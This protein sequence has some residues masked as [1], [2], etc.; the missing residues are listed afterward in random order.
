MRK[1][2]F[3]IVLLGCFLGGDFNWNTIHAQ[4]DSTDIERLQDYN[5]RIMQ[6]KLN[7]IYIPSNIMDA[8][9]ELKEISNEEALNKFKSASE[10]GIGRRLFFGLGKWITT[11]WQLYEG[12]RFSHYLR[13]L[14]L[15]HPDDMAIFVI[16]SFHRHLNGKDLE[17]EKRVEELKEYRR[18][19][20]Q[21]FYQRDTISIDTTKI[22]DKK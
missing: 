7:N 10:E 21:D 14:G 5:W 12:S 3:V 15:T 19:W 4:I 17:I 16:E 1:L 13:G 9:I 20:V 2:S 11:N 18:V 22:E 6:R 8:M